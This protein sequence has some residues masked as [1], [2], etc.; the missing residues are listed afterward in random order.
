MKISDEIFMQQAMELAKQAMAAGEVPVGAVVVMDGHVVG[1]GRNSM[2]GL[3]DPTAHAEVMAIRDAGTGLGKWRLDDATL[4]VTLEPCPMCAGA[5]MAARISR[6]V[7]G[8]P[9]PK[10]GA[11]ASLYTL[12]SDPRLGRPCKVSPMVLEHESSDLLKSFFTDKR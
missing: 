5:I 11:V 2:I 8:A 3:S 12:L 1:R 6:V 10:K 4:Y 9:D 7:Y